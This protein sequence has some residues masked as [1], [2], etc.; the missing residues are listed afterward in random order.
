MRNTT[1]KVNASKD[2]NYA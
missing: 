2:D 1:I